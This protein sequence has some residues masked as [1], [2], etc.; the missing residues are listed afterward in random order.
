[1]SA[2]GFGFS[3]GDIVL[4]ITIIARIVKTLK[5]STA[6]STEYQSTIQYLEHLC[7][8]L[9]LLQN[10]QNR[11]VADH[12][13]ESAIR[14]LSAVAEQPLAQF[15]ADIQRFE[16]SLGPIQ[17]S[18]WKGKTVA[19]LKSVE[20]QLRVKKKVEALKAKIASEMQALHLLL[21][22]Q[23]LYV[24]LWVQQGSLSVK[25]ALPQLAETKS[26]QPR[27]CDSKEMA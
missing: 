20:W 1:M 26:N 3:P 12:P 16:S 5:D 9:Q 15:L 14:A 6:S 21:E 27:I 13:T 17:A 22:G 8:V 2:V 23:M 25:E 19:G 24:H 18:G 10:F 7:L 11:Y 4:G